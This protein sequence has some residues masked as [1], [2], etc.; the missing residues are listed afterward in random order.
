MLPHSSTRSR[1]QTL[2]RQHGPR[3]KSQFPWVACNLNEFWGKRQLTSSKTRGRSFSTI[4]S[5]V[6][7]MIQEL[8]EK[9]KIQVIVATHSPWTLSTKRPGCNLLLQRRTERGKDSAR[10]NSST[11]QVS[12]GRSH[13]ASLSGSRMKRLNCGM[14]HSFARLQRSCSCRDR[15]TNVTS[16]FCVTK[17]LVL[18]VS[19]FMVMLWH[20]EAKNARR[21]VTLHRR[22]SQVGS[23]SIRPFLL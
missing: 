16:R 18:I 6:R 12:V 9:F 22:R 23:P 14:I 7:T 20:M 5:G 10:A 15:Q 17:D 1:L 19:S 13:S 4:P 11:Q 2:V 21:I 3:K 8:A